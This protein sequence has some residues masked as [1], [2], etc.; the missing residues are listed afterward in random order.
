M[1]EIIDG[2]YDF[3]ITNFPKKKWIFSLNKLAF[4]GLKDENENIKL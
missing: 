3:K 1:F 2:S 4:S